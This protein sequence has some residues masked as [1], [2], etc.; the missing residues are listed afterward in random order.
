M[1]VEYI[2]PAEAEYSAPA[3]NLTQAGQPYEPYRPRS[4]THKREKSSGGFTSHES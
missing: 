3:V 4:F 2:L 1:N